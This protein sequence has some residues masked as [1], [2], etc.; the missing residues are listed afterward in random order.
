MSCKTILQ[1]DSI[2]ELANFWDRHDLTGISTTNS[3]RW[4]NLSLS[5]KPSSPF[6]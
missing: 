6:V 1:T 4:T 2:Q 5:V 3:R